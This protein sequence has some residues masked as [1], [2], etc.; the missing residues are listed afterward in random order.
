MTFIIGY[1]KIG[2][3]YERGKM[4]K[5]DLTQSNQ[6]ELYSYQIALLNIVTNCNEEIARVKSK[7]EELQKVEKKGGK[8]DR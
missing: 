5:L 3:K 8:H 1:C 7:L 6:I 4:N 2:Y